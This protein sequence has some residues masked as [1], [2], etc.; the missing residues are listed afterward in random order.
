MSTPRT[1]VLSVLMVSPEFRPLMG[2]YQRAAE[3]LSSALGRTG[4]R[5]VVVTER[6]DRA[7]PAHERIDGYELQRLNCWYRPRL[8]VLS[9]L[10]V[11]AVFLLR[12]GRGFDVWHVHQYGQQAA[13][14]IALGKL[15]RRPV[16]LKL[17]N[18]A[19]MGIRT[20]L[21]EGRWGRVLRYLHRRVSACLATS[22]ETRTEAIEFGIPAERVHLVPNGLDG[23]QFVPV[24]AHA[25][26]AARARLGL[27][28]ERLALFVGRL[29]WEK[30]PLA[31]ID[32]W[33]MIDATQR[34]GATLA[35]VGD[36]PHADA[37]RERVAARGLAASV[38]LAGA[39][40]DVALW[41]QAADFLVIPSHIEGLSNT[42]IEALAS[43]LPVISTRVS[44]SSI[45]VESPPAGA[46]VACGDV[47]AL[48]QAIAGLLADPSARAT[49]AGNARAKFESHFSVATVSRNVLAIYDS[50]H[51]PNARR[52]AI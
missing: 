8:H 27:R 16:L 2:G 44:G 4:A 9:S 51:R 47:A 50:L 23:A 52:R 38:H 11:L 43:G 34:E 5:V 45:L 33:A 15:L 7:W 6:R 46:I 25:R 31:L 42:M 3:R 37:V 41:Y 32:A 10:F 40:E 20:T 13:L 22:P 49:L 21:G 26:G 12:H 36:G 30:N 35:L 39:R 1:A 14:V 29:A 17:T 18:S 24:D 19:D 48:A 28:C